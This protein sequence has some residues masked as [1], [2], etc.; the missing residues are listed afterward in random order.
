MKKER[1]TRIDWTDVGKEEVPEEKR[2][3]FAK[4]VNALAWQAVVKNMNLPMMPGMAINNVI[5]QLRVRVSHISLSVYGPMGLYGI[6]AHY[7]RGVVADIILLDTGVH[8]VPV[9]AVVTE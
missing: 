4:R 8:V 5:K 3:A 6:R 1:T 7:K 2:E 9:C